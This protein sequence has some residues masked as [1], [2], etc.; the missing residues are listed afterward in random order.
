MK[1]ALAC[2]MVLWILLG[3][4]IAAQNPYAPDT[5]EP[6]SVDAIR[7]ATTDPRFV[8]PWVAYTPESRTVPSPSDFMGRIAA[9]PGELATQH[10][11]LRVP[12]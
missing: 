2:G 4:F 11:D 6:G 1:A 10:A 7:A 12:S 9:A 3:V 8:S 5:P